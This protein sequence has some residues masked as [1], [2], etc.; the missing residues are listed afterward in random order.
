MQTHKH[1]I[2]TGYSSAKGKLTKEDFNRAVEALRKSQIPP[3]YYLL[4]NGKIF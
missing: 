2:D 3:P 4:P 1:K